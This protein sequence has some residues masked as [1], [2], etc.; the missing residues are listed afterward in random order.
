MSDTNNSFSYQSDENV[1]SFDDTFA[2]V[3]MDG[4]CALCTFGAQLIDRFDKTGKIR[5]CPVQSPLGRALL[6][7]YRMDPT[8]PE[9]WI[10]LKN[11]ICW[12]S[13]D[14]WIKAA[15]AVGGIGNLMRVFWLVPRSIRD[16]IY[17]RVARNRIAMFGTAD[18]CSLPSP[19]FRARLI[20]DE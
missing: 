7:H 11:G 5:I 17:K 8:D 12:T 14:A 15:E 10:F 13:F 19:S 2:V 20:G 3:V 9:S 4:E 16:W 18:M 1:P 6:V